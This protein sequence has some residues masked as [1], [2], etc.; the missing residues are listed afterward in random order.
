[1]VAAPVAA[2]GAVGA[3]NW[4]HLSVLRPGKAEESE[5]I[6]PLAGPD[7]H[8]GLASWLCLAELEPALA[9]AG[10]LPAEKHSAIAAGQRVAG[11]LIP[12]D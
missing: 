4:K 3:E 5:A 11:S 8:S 7:P 1:M 2:V 9:K 10:R 12:Q 6:W